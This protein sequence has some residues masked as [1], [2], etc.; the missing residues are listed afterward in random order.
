MKV[1]RNHISGLLLPVLVV[2]FAV[3]AAS[4]AGRTP[5]IDTPRGIASLEQVNLGGLDQWILIRGRDASE[6]VLLFLHGGPGS[7]EMPVMPQ[8]AGG[9]EDHFVV[10]HWD[11][12]GAGKSW[13]ADIP[14]DSMTI[15]RFVEDGIEL[16][17][18]LRARFGVEKIYLMGHSWGTI[19]GV[20][21]V[22]REPEK[23]YAYIGIGQCV[24]LE[25]NEA[26]SYRF[27]LEEAKKRNN[28]KAMR[29]LEKIGAPPYEKHRE[30]AQ[31]RKWLQEFGGAFY[32]MKYKELVMTALKAPEYG[33]LDYVKYLYGGYYGTKHLWESILEINFLEQAPSLEVPVYFLEGR[34]DYNTP[35]ELV[36]EYHD[37]LDAPQ[38]KEI[39]WFENSAHSP[40]LEEPD[41]FVRVMAG[42]KGE[43]YLSP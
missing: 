25:R 24:D 33:P 36:Q 3:F 1:Y 15:E 38:G 40:N 17:D 20:L 29:E 5:K 19:L 22:Q 14:E 42:I 32:E 26:I 28:E 30:L 7:P 10:V 2:F 23:F 11:Q 8:Y 21:I 6:P 16:V 4:C 31:Q 39:V 43:T 37:A 13:S 12:R 9:L 27:V 18:L 35:W 34:H 41:R